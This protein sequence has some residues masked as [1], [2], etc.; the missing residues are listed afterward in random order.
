MDNSKIFADNKHGDL[1]YPEMREHLLPLIQAGQSA[2]D[3]GIGTGPMTSPIAFAELS[4]TGVDSNKHRLSICQEAF[5]QANLKHLL[6]AI[7]SDALEYMQTNTVKHHLVIMSDFLMFLTKTDGKEVIRLAYE[8]LLP[9]GYIWITTMSTSDEWYGD[10]SSTQEPIDTDTFM[11]YSHCIG[12]NPICFYHP[13]EIE[14]YLQSMGAKIIFQTEKE[15]N[16][17]G[18]VNIILAQKPA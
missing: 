1:G 11:A 7:E 13:M 9:S 14:E 6:T 17:G 12:A 8:C 3:L 15:N 16:A 2:L 5:A 4:V 10:I 18:M